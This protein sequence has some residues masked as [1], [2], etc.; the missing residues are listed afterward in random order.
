[1]FITLILNSN[2][3]FNTEALFPYSRCVKFDVFTEVCMGLVSLA[4]LCMFVLILFNLFC[5]LKSRG[6]IYCFLLY[7]C[8]YEVP[9]IVLMYNLVFTGLDVE[10]HSRNNY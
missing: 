4:I 1:M 5:N 2:N 6:K 8:P 3:S 9:K 10:G 7:E